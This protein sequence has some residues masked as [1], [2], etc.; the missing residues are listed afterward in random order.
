M[1]GFRSLALSDAEIIRD[2]ILPARAMHRAGLG[3]VD[4]VWGDDKRGIAHILAQRQAKD[5]ITRQEAIQLLEEGLV[6]TIAKG[7]EAR[8]I[9]VGNSTPAL[10][11]PG[12]ARYFG[13]VGWQ[14]CMDADRLSDS[15]ARWPKGRI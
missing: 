10:G 6:Q 4:F 7:E 13:P 1:P 5:G 15:G 14:Q 2:Y 12:A 8:R 11:L 3:W 9:E